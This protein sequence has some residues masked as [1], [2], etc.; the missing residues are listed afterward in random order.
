MLQ[1]Q[2]SRSEGAPGQ[3]VRA[4]VH[5]TDPSAITEIRLVVDEA[6]GGFD[7]A[8]QRSGEGWSV[9]TAVPYE[10]PPGTYSLALRAF[11]ANARLVDSAQVS[12]TVL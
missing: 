12:F 9:E 1:V 2:L 8:L 10:A 7:F 6:G 11:G 3:T 5:S 4:E